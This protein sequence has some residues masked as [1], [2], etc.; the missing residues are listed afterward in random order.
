MGGDHFDYFRIDDAYPVQRKGY[1]NGDYDFNGKINAD[2]YF[3]IDNSYSS[4]GSPL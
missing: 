1:T 2:D 4:H 3:W